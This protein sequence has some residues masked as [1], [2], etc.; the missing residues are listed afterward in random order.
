MNEQK[1]SGSAARDITD[2]F[3]LCNRCGSCR[4]VC[5]VYPVFREEFASARGKVELAEAFFKGEEINE[6]KLQDIFDLCL[7]C[8]TC[9]ENCPSGMRADEVVMTV[10]AEMARRG[11]IPR[12]KRLAL[13][14]LGGMDNALFKLMRAVGLA[15]RV[16]LHGVGGKSPLRFLFPFLG[17]PVDRFVPLPAKKP[18]LSTAPEHSRA[19]DLEA[20]LPD[21]AAVTAGDI[22]IPNHYDRGKAIELIERI[23][24]ARRRNLEAG[25]RAYFFV[26][27]A[28]N[29]F[30]PEEA[31]T[32]MR[33]LKL[34]GIDV[35]APKDQ[36][37]CG[38]PVYFAG[39]IE[40][41]RRVA[42]AA[43]DRFAS[44]RYDLV[45][46]SCSSGGHM[47]KSVFPRL[48][49]LN[50]DGYFEIE[51]DTESESFRRAPSSGKVQNEYPRAADLYREHIEG[52][53]FDINELLAAQLGLEMK[54]MDLTGV[55]KSLDEGADHPVSQNAGS[56]PEPGNVEDTMFEEVA[57]RHVTPIVTYHYPC[58]LNRG[59]GV[60]WQPEAIL[61][62]L[63]GY[64]YVRMEDADRCCGGG[65]SF[66]FLHPDAAEEIARRK[67]DAIDN[68]RADVVATACP[69][70]RIQLMDMLHRRFA[71]HAKHRGERPVF[72]PVMTPT[73]LLLEDL[74]PLLRPPIGD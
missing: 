59:Q 28:V 71:A 51:W 2:D 61:G 56:R 37:C 16:P 68:V 14:A 23:I 53:V 36:I 3:L 22:A 52:K 57:P 38:A 63:P 45:V 62:I 48:F 42:A 13:R 74:A 60:G 6:G 21:P 69:V 11:L 30:F 9:E 67:I 20:V 72:I 12:L 33:V 19:A 35:L 4:S 29:H 34:L 44:H 70:C 65:G 7:H 47:L 66:T 18:F 46:T 41:A 54:V 25:R 31:G 55:F 17:W 73:E 50:A 8:M 26:G 58:H 10:R 43:L 27:H 32:V 5:P 64:R 40:G 24:T 15:R 49:D 39:D 1:K